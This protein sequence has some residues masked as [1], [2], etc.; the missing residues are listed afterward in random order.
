MKTACICVVQFDV[1]LVALQKLVFRCQKC[2]LQV[3]TVER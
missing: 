2:E 3:E 1:F